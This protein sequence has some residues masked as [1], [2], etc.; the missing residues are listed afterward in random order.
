VHISTCY[1]RE[2]SGEGN[3]Y[4]PNLQINISFLKYT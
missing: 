3:I 1:F 2:T 4:P